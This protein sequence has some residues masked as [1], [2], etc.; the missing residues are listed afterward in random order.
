M[1]QQKR[2]PEGTIYGATHLNLVPTVKVEVEKPFSEKLSRTK[3]LIR[4]FVNSPNA[5]VSCSF[6]K[7]SMV[8][9]HLILQE[10]PKIPVVFENTLTE[11]P[12]TLALK[13]KIQQ[14]WNLNLIELRPEK[15]VTFWTLQ[16]RITKEKLHRDDGKKHSNIC[17]YHLK[18]RPF[19]IWRKINGITKSFTGVT[20]CESRHR[21]FVAC[22]KGMDY[23]SHRDGCWKIHPLM[24][25]TPQDIWD[26]IHDNDIPVNEAYAKYGL[27]RIG[28]MW[29]LSHKNW[30]G[31]ISKV[32]PRVY[33]YIMRRYFGTPS[34]LEVTA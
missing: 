15:G 29:C 17:C 22:M 4:F 28:C 2:I 1:Q 20:A 19:A 31:T 13:R 12:E 27:N 24:F 8:L 6:G 11:F 16:D 21:M 32:N 14:E 30:R 18:E 34:L 7:D 3:Q 23:Y 10:N 5:C 33:C 25:W 9:L 26:F